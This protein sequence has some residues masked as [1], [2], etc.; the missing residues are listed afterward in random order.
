MCA[1]RTFEIGKEPA[2]MNCLPF[3]MSKKW[4]AVQWGR[5][6]LKVLYLCNYRELQSHRLGAG[7]A[8]HAV[9]AADER[10]GVRKRGA[11]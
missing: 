7:D 10:H 9:F 3:L 1:S 11:H 6:L 4:E 2:F 8:G 5:A